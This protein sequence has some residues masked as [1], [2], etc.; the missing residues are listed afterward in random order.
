MAMACTG[1]I[2]GF[3]PASNEGPGGSAGRGARPARRASDSR[4]A[5]EAPG[6]ARSR[7][8]MTAKSRKRGARRSDG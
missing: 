4:R 2:G 7:W 6:E 1:V 5:E 3:T 8:R